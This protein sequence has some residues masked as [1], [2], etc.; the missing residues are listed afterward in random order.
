MPGH[1]PCAL[2]SLIVV[3]LW[4]CYPLR[5]Q[6]RNTH[7]DI[8]ALLS[9]DLLFLYAVFNVPRAMDARVS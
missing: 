6:N 5:L 2:K 3:C 4:F 9:L 1:P 7:I 8:L